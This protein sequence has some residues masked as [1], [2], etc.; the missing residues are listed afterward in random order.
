MPDWFGP[1]LAGAAMFAFLGYAFWRSRSVKP[2]PNNRN[3]FP[4][5][6]GGAGG[7]GGD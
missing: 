4:S 1:L 3:D 2:D 6:G 7:G 5:V